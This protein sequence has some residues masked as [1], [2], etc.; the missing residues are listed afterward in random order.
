MNMEYMTLERKYG[1][2][3]NISVEV[4]G[5]FIIKITISYLILIIDTY[6]GGCM[7]SEIDKIIR[8]NIKTLMFMHN[9]NIKSLSKIIG[10]HDYS[11]RR[12][13]NGY[14]GLSIKHLELYSK[15]FKITPC[16]LLD[17]NL[18]KIRRK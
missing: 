13:L 3:L 1:I 6:P 9:Y 11:V 5:N 2:L 7:Y 14:T 4:D 12:Q 16:Q 10:T 18:I 15:A 17:K 8:C